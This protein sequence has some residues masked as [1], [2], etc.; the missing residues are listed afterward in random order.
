MLSGRRPVRNVA[1]GPRQECWA[2][3]TGALPFSL[4]PP[5]SKSPLF[6]Q[7]LRVVD[8]PWIGNGMRQDS[9]IDRPIYEVFVLVQQV[10]HSSRI[11]RTHACTYV[12]VGL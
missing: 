11:G 4:V 8:A 7:R 2:V 6:A 10:G 3:F 1:L 12:Y 9:S 5:V